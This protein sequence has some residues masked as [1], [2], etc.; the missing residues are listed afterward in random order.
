MC[1]AKPF[2]YAHLRSKKDGNAF[3]RLL[4]ETLSLCPAS[5]VRETEVLACVARNPS[6]MP[7]FALR[8]TEVLAFVYCMKPFHNAHL[9]S[10][11]DGNAC[12]RLLRKTLSLCPASDL[13][14]TEVLAFVCCTKPFH[15]APPLL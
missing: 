5:D 3:L 12:L 7:T 1:C 4:R 6:T 9:R 10:K 8:K 13:R 2:H 11:K 14:E 15:C